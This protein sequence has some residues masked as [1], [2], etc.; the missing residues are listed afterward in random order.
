MGAACLQTKVVENIESCIFPPFLPVPG[1]VDVEHFAVDVVVHLPVVVLGLDHEERRL[2]EGDQVL[3]K[4]HASPLLACR[5]GN[6][7]MRG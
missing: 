5:G 2:D 6:E 4:V 1:C 7:D 3:G